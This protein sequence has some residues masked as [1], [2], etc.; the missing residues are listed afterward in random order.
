MAGRRNI[1]SRTEPNHRW[2][3][4][5]R[6]TTPSRY[7]RM[8]VGELSR[9]PAWPFA[10]SAVSGFC[11]SARAPASARVPAAT[12]AVSSCASK[13]GCALAAGALAPE[14]STGSPD[15]AHLTVSVRSDESADATGTLQGLRLSGTP[16]ARPAS[17]P[18]MLD[19]PVVE[20]NGVAGGAGISTG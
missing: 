8:R 20:R 1:E 13:L 11:T 7:S 6:K 2:Q 18:D 10:M 14:A 5:R 4:A 3:A 17:E 9:N 16:P 12:A 19:E 15:E